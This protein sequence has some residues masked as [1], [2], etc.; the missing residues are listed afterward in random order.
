MLIFYYL[1]SF[2]CLVCM[3]L[4]YEEKLKEHLPITNSLKQIHAR[5]CNWI[6]KLYFSKC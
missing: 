2:A 4:Y 1:A 3:Y 6:E 5:K